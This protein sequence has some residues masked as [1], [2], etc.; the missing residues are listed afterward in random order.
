MPQAQAPITSQL[1]LTAAQALLYSVPANTTLQ[2]QSVVLTNTTSIPRT[3]A[4]NIVAPAGAV[5]PSTLFVNKIV[6]PADGQVSVPWL[7]LR[8][9]TAGQSIWGAA[10][11]T[12][13]VNAWI[14]GVLIS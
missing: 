10:D 4:F 8:N 2:I 12:G 13:V 9:L 6:V 5:G 11:I 3:A 1:Q 7:V 14:S